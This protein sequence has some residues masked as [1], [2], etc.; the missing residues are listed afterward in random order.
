LR[1]AGCDTGQGWFFGRPMQEE[2]MLRWL[3]PAEE[4]E[5]EPGVLALT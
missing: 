1:D 4:A 3:T 2:A 5:T